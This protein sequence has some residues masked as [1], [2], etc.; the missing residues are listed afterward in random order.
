MT[1]CKETKNRIWTYWWK[2]VASHVVNL[3]TRTGCWVKGSRF[4][5][6]DQ[7]DSSTAAHYLAGVWIQSYYSRRVW[8]TTEIVITCKGHS[9]KVSPFYDPADGLKSTSHNHEY[10]QWHVTALSA[11]LS[12]Y[13]SLRA[14]LGLYGLGFTM[15]DTFEF[16]RNNMLTVTTNKRFTVSAWKILSLYFRELLALTRCADGIMSHVNS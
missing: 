5:Y 6:D 10:N 9:L 7:S 4:N 8:A 16:Q 15:Q 14:E 11:P 1:E 2:A 3:H 13:R 12:L